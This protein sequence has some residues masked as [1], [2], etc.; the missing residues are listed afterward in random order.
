MYVKVNLN[1]IFNKLWTL[2]HGQQQRHPR[3]PT[4]GFVLIRT[5]QAGI[6][7]RNRCC[8]RNQAG[9]NSYAVKI[10]YVVKSD[11][12]SKTKTFYWGNIQC[13]LLLLQSYY[14]RRNKHGKFKIRTKI[15]FNNLFILIWRLVLERFTILNYFIMKVFLF[16]ST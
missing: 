10:P 6:V 12:N 7:A 14:Y 1:K 2:P 3:Q 5:H 11:K 9:L 4:T 13:K 15:C 8:G 16:F